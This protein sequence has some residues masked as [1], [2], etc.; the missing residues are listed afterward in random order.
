MTTETTMTAPPAGAPRSKSAVRPE[1]QALRAVA[2]SMVILIHL[3]PSRLTGGYAGV[4]VFFVI[5]GFLITAHLVREVDRTGRISLAQ[6]WARRVRRLL[7]ASLT[8]LLVSAIAVLLVVPKNLWVQFL[9]EIAA[10]ATYVL[11]WVLAGDAVDYLAADNVA[12]PAQHYWSLSVEEQF[13]VVWP[14]VIILAIFIATKWRGA[15]RTRVIALLLAVITVA[16]LAWSIYLTATDPAAAYFVTTTRAWEFGIGGLLAVFASSPIAG[17]DRLRSAVSWAGGLAIAFTAFFYNEST[18]FPGFTALLP[19]LG[20][21]AVI[22][23]GSPATRWALT[24][25][26]S[27]RPIQWL[28]DVSYSAYL[29]HWPPIILGAYF[30]G[31]DL[32]IQHKLA[33]LAFTLVAAWLSKK[34]IEDPVREH[35]FLASRKPRFTFIAMLVGMAVV[36]AV[37]GGVIASVTV[38]STADQKIIDKAT[39]DPASCLG[40]MSLMPE[41]NCAA[42]ATSTLIPD[43]ALVAEDTPDVYTDKCRSQPDDPTVRSCTFGTGTRVALIGDSHSASWF[44]ALDIIA[45]A[46]N[47]Q[48]T[49]YFKASCRFTA[50]VS[51][52]PTDAP[53]ATWNTD[54]QKVLAKAKPYTF[55]FTAY[56]ASGSDGSTTTTSKRYTATLAGFQQAWQPLIARGSTIVG[57]HDTPLMTDKTPT[58]LAENLDDPT[59]CSITKAKAL[60]FTDSLYGAATSTTGAVGIDLND[61]FCVSDECLTAIGGVAVWRD[62]HHF[63]ATYSQTL[64]PVLTQRLESAGV[65]TKK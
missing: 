21:A 39:T 40:A 2:V 22:W 24:R 55:V 15:H 9:R 37:P 49:T 27:I 38:G 35:R 23:A 41:R 12:S 34:F 63:T 46:N 50:Q 56:R 36:L 48:I 60:R 44:P 45:K 7:P 51:G 8:V 29:W 5:S 61:Y 30:I 31:H 32:R 59:T 47:W 25:L 18:P 20:T 52:N 19:A 58:C 28:G 53:C 14:L 1:I 43:P 65:I 64:A 4:D 13:Y 42:P 26:G 33:I 17:R 54:V 10:A 6:F 62:N 16:S 3:F 11:N 57:L